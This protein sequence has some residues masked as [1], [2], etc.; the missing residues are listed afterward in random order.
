MVEYA[1]HED[2]DP[3]ENGRIGDVMHDLSAHQ[4]TAGAEAKTESNHMHKDEQ[5]LYA[6]KLRRSPLHQ[7]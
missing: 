2:Q 4:E 5:V 7:T 3:E 6:L 1:E